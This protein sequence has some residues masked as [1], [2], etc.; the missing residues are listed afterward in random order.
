MTTNTYQAI[1]ELLENRQPRE[2][3][4]MLEPL[5][6]DEPGNLSLR[7]LRAWGLFARAALGPAEEELRHIVE[8]DPSDVWARFTLGRTLERQSRLAEALRIFAWLMRCPATSSTRWRACGWSAP[9]AGSAPTEAAEHSQDSV[10]ISGP[11][12]VTRIVCSNWAT[13]DLSL[14]VTVQLSAHMSHSYVPSDSIGST[15]NVMPASM[16]VS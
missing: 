16:I 2:A 10:R 9:W 5:I 6:A 11:S 8:A 1:R 13:R 7:V 14:V 12:S 15:V 4:A 3:L